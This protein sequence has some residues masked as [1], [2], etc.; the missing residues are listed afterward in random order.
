MWGYL[1][2]IS[3]TQLIG[4]PLCYKYRSTFGTV[5]YTILHYYVLVVTSGVQGNVHHIQWWCLLCYPK[6]ASKPVSKTGLY[7]TMVLFGVVFLAK[8]LAKMLANILLGRYPIQHLAYNIRSTFGTV[9]YTI[10]HYYVLLVFPSAKGS[11]HH[12]Y[13]WCLLCYPKEASKPVS[14]TGLYLTMVLFGVVFLAKMLA[15]ILLGRYPIYPLTTSNGVYIWDGSVHHPTLL[16]TSGYQWC[17]GECPSYPM[18]VFIVLPKQ[19]LKQGIFQAPFGILCVY[20]GCYSQLICQL[21]RY[22]KQ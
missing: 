21:N 19:H 17:T 18:V 10:L 8:M 1:L 16:C 6:E 22:P 2:G 5:P 12:I 4:Y 11:V 20:L 14:K 7:L 9:P 3:P 13:W 15:N